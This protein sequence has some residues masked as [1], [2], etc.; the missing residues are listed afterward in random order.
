MLAVDFRYATRDFRDHSGVEEVRFS[1]EAGSFFGI[2]GPTQS[3]KSTLLRLMFDYIHPAS[4]EIAVFDWDSVRDSVK[5]RASAGYVPAHVRGHSRM[6]ARQMIYAMNRS[7]AR[8][9]DGRL[10][11]LCARFQLDPAMR[12]D[13]LDEGDRRKLAFICVLLQDPPL[14]AVDEPSLNLE[15]FERE[16]VFE[17]LRR[18]HA[19]GTT[20]L[21]TTRSVDEIV[22]YCTHTAILQN[23]T[24]VHTGEVAQMDFLRARRI[25]VLAENAPEI[26]SALGIV[27]FH[28]DAHSVSFTYAGSMDTLIKTL[29]SF[30]IENLRIEEPTMQSVMIANFVTEGGHSNAL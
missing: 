13:K 16:A 26:A 17:E 30:T 12:F 1:V 9:D 11:E 25:T 2:L 3:G 23:G 20:V 19:N 14:V 27:N 21:I 22:E 24:V 5:I 10:A 15:P 8:I 7:D 29:S 4:G 6:T 28:G 18:L